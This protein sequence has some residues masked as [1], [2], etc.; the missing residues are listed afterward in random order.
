MGIKMVPL[1]TFRRHALP[2]SC[3]LCS[4]QGGASV[5]RGRMLSLDI[6]KF[7]LMLIRVRI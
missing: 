1:R 5:D 6:F 4:G 3:F 7:P 2:V